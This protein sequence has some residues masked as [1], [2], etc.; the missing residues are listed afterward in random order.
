MRAAIAAIAL[1]A[2]S[3]APA[4]ARSVKAPDQ[5]PPSP[6]YD[7]L[8]YPIEPKPTPR[9]RASAK[10]KPTP[11]PA[12]LPPGPFT[13]KYETGWNKV[14]SLELIVDQRG[15]RLRGALTLVADHRGVR[16]TT[17]ELTGKA[18]GRAGQFRWVDAYGNAGTATLWPNGP[19]SWRLDA[20]IRKA[21]DQGRW[22]EG[23]Y[24]LKKTAE[25]LEPGQAPL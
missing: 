22:F 1:V 12:K 3:A 11:D 7:E 24:D 21:T 17:I 23:H 15:A 4:A 16:V 6:V 5:L 25:K 18:E 20:I 8:G 13:G 2:L 9:P 19:T 14:P 10:P